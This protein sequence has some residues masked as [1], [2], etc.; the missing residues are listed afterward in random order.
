LEGIIFGLCNALPL[1]LVTYNRQGDEYDSIENLLEIF[2]VF[3]KFFILH[4]LLQGSGFYSNFF[5]VS[6]LESVES[7]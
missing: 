6:S 5:G 7:V 4:V 2:L 1:L 3:I